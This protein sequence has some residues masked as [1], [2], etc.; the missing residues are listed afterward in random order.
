[1]YIC[2]YFFIDSQSRTTELK[3]T[4]QRY[5]QSTFSSIFSHC[6]TI[7]I[8]QCS[9]TLLTALDIINFFHIYQGLRIGLEKKCF[10]TVWLCISLNS[11][12]SGVKSPCCPCAFLLVR[13]DFY[14]FYPFFFWPHNLY[15]LQW[16]L[17]DII[18]FLHLLFRSSLYT[19]D[20]FHSLCLPD[21]SHMFTSCKLLRI[22]IIS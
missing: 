7:N 14:S 18:H 2:F 8:F 17:R 1:M 21:K 13:I 4:L 5:F 15:P 22:M 19:R 3:V 10:L 12:A 20:I 6:P 16:K 9:L 11:I